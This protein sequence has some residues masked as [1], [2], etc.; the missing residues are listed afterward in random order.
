M[1]L[2][3]VGGSGYVA[4]LV[5]PILAEQFA[6][7]I[8]DRVPPRDPGWEHVVG[9]V[10]DAAALRTAAEQMDLLLYMAMGKGSQGG[11]MDANA[12]YDVNVKG[13]HFALDAAAKAGIRRAVYTSSLSVYDGHDLVSGRY[14]QE[15]VPPEP[16]SVYGLTKWMGEEVCRFFHH[17]RGLPVLALRLFLPVSQK[18]WHARHDTIR[19]DARTSAPDLARALAAALTLDHSGF[20]VIHVTGDTSGCAFHHEKAKRLL[21]WEPQERQETP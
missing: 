18:D 7:R 15:T 16:H 9:D 3:V 8:F 14:D 17:T 20:E 4:G 10:T 1:R 13:L 11:V 21:G 5:L 2:L 6:L 19:P 12:A